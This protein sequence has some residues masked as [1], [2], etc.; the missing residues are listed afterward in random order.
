M[1]GLRADQERCRL[2]QVQTLP[3]RCDTAKQWLRLPGSL[4]RS[5][6]KLHEEK[7]NAHYT[8]LTEVP[9]DS[10]FLDTVL[11][12]RNEKVHRSGLGLQSAQRDHQV[13]GLTRW[14][15]LHVQVPE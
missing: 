8:H 1:E 2:E 5:L 15:F 13:L 4:E 9:R 3:P 11:S 14:K 6:D 12:S 10:Y 7:Y